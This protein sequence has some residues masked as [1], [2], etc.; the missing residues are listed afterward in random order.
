[1]RVIIQRVLNASVT[2]RGE[3]VAAIDYGLLL[4]L[5]IQKD[6]RDEDIDYIVDKVVHLRIFPNRSGRFDHSAKDVNASMLLI[7]QF[8][9]YGDTRK[10]R[11]PSFTQSAPTSKALGMFSAAI[12]KFRLTGL[13]LNHGPFQE[14]MQISLL[15]DGPVTIIIDSADRLISRK[16][17]FDRY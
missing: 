3:M 8:T 9:L 12:E 4:F 11:R 17:K 7:S 10:G 16:T 14:N 5:A 15:N 13:E 6:D 2:V 1:M